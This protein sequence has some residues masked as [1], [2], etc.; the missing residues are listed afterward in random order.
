MDI[1]V[2]RTG[3][4]W[5]VEI[6]AFRARCAIGRGGVVRDKREGDGGTPAGRWPMRE[7][8]YRADR[9]PPPATRLRLTAIDPNDG[10]CDAPNHPAY[11]RLVRLPF[12]AG[13]EKMWRDDAVYDLVV[14][15]G[16]N[17]DP[18]EPGKGSAIFAHVSRAGY[19][20]TEGCVALPLEE[21]TQLLALAGPETCVVVEP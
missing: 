6:G 10:W 8:F 11:N 2:R 18:V 17:D 15:L 20:P 1:F 3:D 5:N 19:A 13:H 9:I 21:L 7:A 16:Y 4:L 14:V 12:A